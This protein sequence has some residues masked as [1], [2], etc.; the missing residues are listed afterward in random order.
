[1]LVRINV[2]FPHREGLFLLCVLRQRD[3][4]S[5]IRHVQRLAC[6][7]WFDM[8]RCRTCRSAFL[9]I[10]KY[11]DRVGAGDHFTRFV[12]HIEVTV[13]VE[14]FKLCGKCP[15]RDLLPQ[16]GITVYDNLP[17][18]EHPRFSVMLQ[19]FHAEADSF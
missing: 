3:L 19:S 4:P 13:S 7:I 8:L 9:K 11:P 15:C 16:F 12:F 18:G 6:A 10:H 2:I 17:V 14:P 1:M 5:L